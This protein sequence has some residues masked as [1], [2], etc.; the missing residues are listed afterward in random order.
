[1]QRQR[2][3]DA[4]I[5]DLTVPGGMGG[6]ET[7]KKLLEIDNEVKGI[8]S[9]G[10]CNDPILSN[11]REYGFSGVVEKP[12]NVEEQ[13]N[14]VQKIISQNLQKNSCF[15]TNLLYQPTMQICYDHETEIS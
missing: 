14:T 4:V 9:S 12:Y 5:M 15:V 7:M 10:Y 8:V 11:Y 6:K 1:M 2:P 13:I 3:F